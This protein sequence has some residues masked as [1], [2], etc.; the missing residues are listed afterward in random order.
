M[1]LA[2][3]DLS[4]ML[5]KEGFKPQSNGSWNFKELQNF[6]VQNEIKMY[7]DGEYMDGLSEETFDLLWNFYST[8]ILTDDSILRIYSNRFADDILNRMK[9]V[10][11]NHSS[12]H[13]HDKKPS[14]MDD[15]VQNMLNLL[16]GK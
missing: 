16:N 15:N 13:V 14:S 12:N 7:A 4:K 1:R 11:G 10:F 3:L 2:Y 8:R 9:A 6:F 5:K